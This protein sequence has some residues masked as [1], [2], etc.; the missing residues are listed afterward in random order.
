MSYDLTIPEK[1]CSSTTYNTIDIG[2]VLM[3]TA[4][5]PILTIVG[6]T[7]IQGQSVL[8]SALRAG[9]YKIR[10]ITRNPNSQAAKKLEDVG[11]E[12]AKADLN[13]LSSLINAFEGTTY[14]FAMTNFFEPFAKHDAKTAMEIEVTQG[15]NIAKAAADCSTLKHY[16]WSTLPHASKISKGEWP[17]PHFDGKAQVNDYIKGE[18]QLWEKTTFL[19]VSSYASNFTFPM[20][21]PN[22][23]VR[24]STA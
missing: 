11:V 22:L 6:A 10:A 12:V 1:Q 23:L 5:L 4:S 8:N 24:L 19:W 13:D 14:L 20:F 16:I 21:T 15:V 3:D 9:S 2:S 17:V 7:G 18:K